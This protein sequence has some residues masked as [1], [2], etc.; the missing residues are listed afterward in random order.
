VAL[1]PGYARRHSDRLQAGRTLS[2]PALR[3]ASPQKPA[4]D[5]HEHGHPRASL[6]SWKT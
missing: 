2:L 6:F 3:I 1:F 5:R 4:R